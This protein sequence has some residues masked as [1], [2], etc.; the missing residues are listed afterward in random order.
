MSLIINTEEACTHE[1]IGCR[2]GGVGGLQKCNMQA[3]IQLLF[4]EFI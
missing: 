3:L 4:K 1:N 2:G